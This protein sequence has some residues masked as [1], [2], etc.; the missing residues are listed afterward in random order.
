[1]VKAITFASVA[2]ALG[3]MPAVARADQVTGE[4]VVTQGHYSS[5]CRMVK[6]VRSDTGTEM[7]FRIPADNSDILA[8]TM[9]ALVSRVRVT[10]SFT[11]GVTTG[12]G[13][14]PRIEWISLLRD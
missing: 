1:M 5:A 4:I 13:T 6:L 2:V 8:V 12:C 7:W 14:E 3:M 11:P 10:I 9:T